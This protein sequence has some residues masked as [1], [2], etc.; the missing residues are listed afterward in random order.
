MGYV[1]AIAGK[2]GTGKT[3]IAALIVRLLKENQRGSILAVDAD[4]NSNL[5]EALGINL[6]NS[7]GKILDGISA[8]PQSVPAGMPKERFIEYELQQAIA[9][10]EGFDLLAMGKPEGPGCYCY[11]NNC[12]RGLMARLSADY[13][14]LVIDNEAGLEHLSR[15]TARSAD[16]LLVVSDATPV[17]LKAAAR[18]SAL[19]EEL[20]FAVK[21]K[22]L[23]L[24]RCG[25][26]VE[27]ISA[28]PEPAVLGRIP[29]DAAVAQASLSGRPLWGLGADTAA[30][31]A[32]R[33]LGDKIWQK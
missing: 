9:E 31:S 10:G 27:K 32:L 17:G 3:T 33:A 21:K 14:Y 11:V 7:V 20:K 8:N 19:A 29:E 23:L 2:G 5:G 24:N 13:D 12:L 25:Q 26:P 22:F 16:T 18:I 6:E 30:L 28:P 4:P 1:I 15:R